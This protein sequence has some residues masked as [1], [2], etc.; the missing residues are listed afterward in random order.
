M[1]TEHDV[2]GV[3]MHCMG[4]EPFTSRGVA[5]SI[6]R[7]RKRKRAI[8]SEVYKCQHCRSWHIGSPTRKQSMRG[9]KIR[10]IK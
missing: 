8:A 4:K 1:K 7:R 5:D 10:R 6:A 3:E 2:V 9:S